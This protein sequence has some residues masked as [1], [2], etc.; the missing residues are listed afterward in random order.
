MVLRG[1][2]SPS[3]SQEASNSWHHTHAQRTSSYV[4][5]VTC[6][7]VSAS[8]Q[9]SAWGCRRGDPGHRVLLYSV[10]LNSASFLSGVD[11]PSTLPPTGPGCPCVS[12]SL[13]TLAVASFLIAARLLGINRYHIAGFICMSLMSNNLE[14][15][16][17]C[18]LVFWSFNH[19]WL[20]NI[21]MSIY[22]NSLSLTDLQNDG[23]YSRCW[24]FA[25]LKHYK[26]ILTPVSGSLI[27]SM[28]SF[29]NRHLYVNVIKLIILM[30]CLILLKFD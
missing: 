3:C 28:I 11:A 5:L 26:H 1:H 24:L 7:P 22:G 2:V 23:V 13:A 27:L 19:W 30:V 16:G 21:F 25:S 18:L 9:A 14:Y 6:G 17:I 8:S 4:S 15:L 29:M 10:W 20:S 12:V